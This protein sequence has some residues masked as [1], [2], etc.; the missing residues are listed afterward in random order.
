MSLY[1]INCEQFKVPTG[2]RLKELR[3][4]MGE[5]S[6]RNEDIFAY[7]VPSTDAHQVN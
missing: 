2:E 5:Y 4:L 6:T 7:I 1:A 3:K